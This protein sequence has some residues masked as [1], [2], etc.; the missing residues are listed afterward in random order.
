[1]DALRHAIPPAWSPQRRVSV[2]ARLPG[3]ATKMLLPMD[4]TVQTQALYA[5]QQGPP[6]W[7]GQC[8]ERL[9]V[10]HMARAAGA[11]LARI[12]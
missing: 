7:G 6:D 9:D 2:Q 4:A 11:K 5:L 12:R 3:F 10:I 1:M 8:C